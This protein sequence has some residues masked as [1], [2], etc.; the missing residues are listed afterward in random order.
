MNIN[1]VI[2]YPILSEKSYQQKENDVYIFAVDVRTNKAEV[3]KV[4]E[5][6][7]DVKV[8]KVNILSVSKKPKNVG[9]FKGFTNRFKKAF[10][11]LKKGNKINIFPEESNE[12]TKKDKLTKK[13]KIEIQKKAI[14]EKAAA[15]IAAQKDKKSLETNTKEL[16]NKL[17]EKK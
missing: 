5:Y 8:K 4:V 17:E 12:E 9:K 16:K 10:V 11:T 13:E 14:E 3:K 7:F 15:K 1:E 6:I 2:K